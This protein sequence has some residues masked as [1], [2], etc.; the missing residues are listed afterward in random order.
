MI[1]R[2]D[3]VDEAMAYLQSPRQ[4]MGIATTVIN[5]LSVIEGFNALP[6]PFRQEIEQRA[7]QLYG[8]GFVRGMLWERE[9]VK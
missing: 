5:A 9:R 2:Q 4:A 1:A 3:A 6:D 8:A 7:A